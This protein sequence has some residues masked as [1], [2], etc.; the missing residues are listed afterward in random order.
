MI[1]IFVIVFF[2]LIELHAAG[3][4]S[5]K[6]Y[7]WLL[8]V[9]AL[10][11]KKEYNLAL[12]SLSKLETVS[13]NRPYDMAYIHQTFGYIYLEIEKPGFAVKRFKQAL[14]G[15]QLPVVQTLN[16]LQNLA[17]LHMQEERYQDAVDS[18]E[19]WLKLSEQKKP[20]IYI[21]LAIALAQLGQNSSA[22][23]AAKSAVSLSKAA[24][25]EWYRLLIALY[26]KCGDDAGMTETLKTAVRLFG[27]KK[28]YLDQLFGIYMKQ[29]AYADAL[30]IQ[31]LAYKNGFVT[32]EE[33][34]RRLAMLYAYNKTPL[35]A[36]TVMER[37]LKSGVVDG[38]EANLT[39]LYEY[40]VTAR[41]SE[42]AMAYLAKAA[43]LA[44][45]GMLYLQLAQMLFEAERYLEAADTITKALEKGGLKRPEEAHLL[46]G[47]A[48]YEGGK[49]EKAK[50]CFKR[51][52]EFPHKQESAASWLRYLNSLG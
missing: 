49:P 28:S 48:Y 41:E 20:E 5:G 30:V 17:A 44:Q 50:A 42:R 37:G 14:Q 40:F 1:R 33:E 6:T 47:V 9:Q 39:T 27:P 51:L 31:E 45:D 16:I 25:E 3:M 19:Q 46:Q 4:L 32:S 2:L 35:D 38:N 52:E 23:Q 29:E 24:K 34:I 22:L 26:H 12:D 18:L 10:M 43:K 13:K 8:E 11:E 21:T 7:K 36:A 15:E